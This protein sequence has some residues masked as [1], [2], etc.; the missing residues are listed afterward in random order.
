MPVSGAITRRYAKGSN[1]GIDI[2]APRGTDVKAAAAGRVAAITK[3]TDGVTI[4]VI[5]H[6]GELMSVYAG[7]GDL[8]VQRGAQVK[9]GEKIGNAG[10][11]GQ[12]HFEV[13][14]GFESVDPEKYL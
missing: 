10:G 13:R 3:D 9:A 5:R 14:Q 6:E 8:S 12:L 4:V 11:S 1:D 2:S 7:V